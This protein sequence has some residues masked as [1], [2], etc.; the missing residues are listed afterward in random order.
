MVFEVG[1]LLCPHGAKFFHLVVPGSWLSS[2]E[3]FRELFHAAASMSQ[4]PSP[5]SWFPGSVLTVTSPGCGPTSRLRLLQCL[6]THLTCSL[7]RVFLLPE[8]LGMAT[9]GGS[10]FP[11]AVT[12]TSFSPSLRCLPFSSL[13]KPETFCTPPNWRNLS[14]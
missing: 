12:N 4:M 5:R 1:Q 13:A 9:D 10:T 2:A 7:T 8:S 6:C 11:V 14:S 3:A